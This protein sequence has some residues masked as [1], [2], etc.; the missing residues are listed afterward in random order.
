MDKPASKPDG[1][2][3]VVD[4]GR[5]CGKCGY[6]LTSLVNPP[7]CPECGMDF[8]AVI[9]WRHGATRVAVGAVLMLLLL[10]IALV[11]TYITVFFSSD[12][13]RTSPGGGLMFGGDME[14]GTFPVLGMVFVQFPLTV[15]A[16]F[17]AA[18][19]VKITRSRLPFMIAAGIT[20]VATAINLAFAGLAVL[21]VL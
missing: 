18:F 13:W 20:C 14:P 1:T 5:R 2:E 4:T 19:G 15:I 11:T 9:P 7:R 12:Y 16:V 10:I 6:N 21:Q 3:P 17:V 8:D